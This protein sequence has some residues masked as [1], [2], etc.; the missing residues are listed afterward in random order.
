[1]LQEGDDFGDLCTVGR[2]ILKYM[3]EKYGA[4]V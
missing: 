1:M 3:L 4:M 2:I